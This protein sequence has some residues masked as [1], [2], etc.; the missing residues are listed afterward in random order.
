MQ[1]SPS[2]E[3]LMS[4]PS[5]EMIGFCHLLFAKLCLPFQYAEDFA[6]LGCSL[7]I[8]PSCESLGE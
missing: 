2:L 5:A 1:M 3:E 8:C 6:D 7:A 4:F